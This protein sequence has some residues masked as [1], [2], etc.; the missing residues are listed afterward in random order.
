VDRPN[1]YVTAFISGDGTTAVI[2]KTGGIIS[3]LDGLRLP[4]D[5][6]AQ[7]SQQLAL[8]WPTYEGAPP[9]PGAAA[10]GFAIADDGSTVTRADSDVTVKCLGAQFGYADGTLVQMKAYIK[11]GD[12]PWQPLFGGSI[13]SGTGGEAVTIPDVPAGTKVL[14]KAEVYD[15]Y[16]RD[17]L[18]RYGWPLNYTAND[19][20]GQVVTLRNGDLPINNNPS[21]P[22]QVG[23]GSLLAPLVDP[24]TGRI[25]LG[26]DQAIYCFDFNPLSTGRGIDYNDVC[27]MA[28]ATVAGE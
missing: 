21:Y 3:K 4:V 27:I 9:P 8:N 16:S 17:L 13:L 15:S 20:T 28:T 25:S 22:C 10:G 6:L 18:T 5:N 14:V 12:G 11:V 23:V 24:Q 26:D 2:L 19:G 7:A 1:Y